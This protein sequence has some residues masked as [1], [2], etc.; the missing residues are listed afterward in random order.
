MAT[1]KATASAFSNI[2][3]IKYWGNLD[4]DLRLP[5]SGSLSMSLDGLATI[6]T[7]EFRDDLT[8]DTVSINGEIVTG[9]PHARVAHHLD[10]VRRLAE[11]TI[12]ATVQSANNFPTGAGI[13]SS[14]SAFAAL[15]LAATAALGL[16]LSE[17]ELST[18]ARLGSGSA[19]RS[20]PAGFVEW[21]KGDTH[22]TSYA[23]TF[24]P[25]D[26][27]PLIDLIAV[28]SHDHKATG[29]TE[30]HTLAA[31]SP[32]QAARLASAPARLAE[33][34]RAILDR[35]FEK[36]AAVTEL[37]STVMHSVMMTGT[38]ALFY[39]EPVTLAV[40]AAVRGWRASGLEVCYTI[41]A[42]ANVHCLALASSAD[43]VA[44]RLRGIEGVQ[45]VLRAEAG[46]A[47]RLIQP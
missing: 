33:C 44:E 22:E 14:A 17:R 35:D 37:D 47:A 25:P 19:A 21:Y 34:K 15:S 8:G 42:G 12:Y 32:L 45:D 10:H 39:W 26:H 30:G 5:A 1:P 6:T 27:W 13:A 43:A 41:D 28:V 9:T 29:S 7:V 24:A 2:A 23:E 4:D 36:F 11:H 18:L 31:T 16:N 3:T 40:M 20:I 46:G 38:P